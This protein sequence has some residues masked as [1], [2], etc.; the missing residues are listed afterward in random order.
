MHKTL[1]DPAWPRPR[2]GRLDV[3]RGTQGA[4]ARAAREPAG[5]PSGDAEHLAALP[6]VE[7]QARRLRATWKGTKADKVRDPKLTMDKERGPI[8]D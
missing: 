4:S 5:R 3:S 2:G 7:S 6:V 8:D 1:L